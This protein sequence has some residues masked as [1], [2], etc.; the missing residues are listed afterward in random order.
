MGD[1]I[2]TFEWDGQTV[3]KETKGFVGSDCVNKTKFIEKSLG[4]IDGKRKFK[5]EYYEDGEKESGER[6]RLR[7]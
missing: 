2:L 1:L 6:D 5:A 7:N 4:E 3:H